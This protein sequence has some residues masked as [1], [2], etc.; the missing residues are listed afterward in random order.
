MVSELQLQIIVLK[1]TPDVDFGLQKGSGNNYVIDQKQKAGAHDLSFTFPVKIK[2]DKIKDG[3]PKISGDF[4]QGPADQKFVYINS[5]T[6]A[7]QIGSIWTRRLKVPLTG[8]TWDDIDQ[9]TGDSKLIL[10]TQVQG[11]GKDGGPNC[12]TVKPFVGWRP[13]RMAW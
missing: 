8:I 9:L 13:I 7:G 4:V 12:G 11:T 3:S 6:S 10:S 5:G 2:G 1:P